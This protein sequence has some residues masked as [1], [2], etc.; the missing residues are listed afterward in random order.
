[1]L[2]FVE[3]GLPLAVFIVP[4]VIAAISWLLVPYALLHESRALRALR[5]YREYS[6]EKSYRDILRA[7]LRDADT[8]RHQQNPADNTAA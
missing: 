6:G 3:R 2:R 4:M 5:A 8:E 1:M 7:A